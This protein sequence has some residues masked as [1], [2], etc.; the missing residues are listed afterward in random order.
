MGVAW[1]NELCLAL[2]QVVMRWWLVDWMRM[3]YW[4]G[5]DGWWVNPYT[6]LLICYP[7]WAGGVRM[8]TPVAFVEK[9]YESLRFLKLPLSS[10][11]CS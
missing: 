5:D 2:V 1:I 11:P 7:L 8:T 10:K 3:L 9:A 6:V 4:V